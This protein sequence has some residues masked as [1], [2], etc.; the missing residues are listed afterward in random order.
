MATGRSDYPNQVNNVLGFPFIFRGALDVA[1]QR[2]QRGDEAGGR[3]TRWPTLAKEDVPDS[4]LRAYGGKPFQFGR[5]YIIPKPFDSRVLLWEAPA[6]AEAAMETGVARKPYT[7]KE[8][9]VRELESRAVAHPRGACAWSSTR[10]QGRAQAHRLPRGRAPE[11]PARRQDPGRGG[12]RTA[13][14]ARRRK[15]AIDALPEGV[16]GPART[17]SRSSTRPPTRSFEAYAE[18][19]HELRQRKGV[20]PRGRG[21]GAAAI[22]I[23][24]GIMMV[25]EGDADG[26]IAGLTSTTPRPSGRRCRSSTRRAGRLSAWPA[27]TC[28]SFEDGMIFIA[29]TTVNIDPTAEELAEIAVLAADVADTTSTSSRAWRCSRSPTS[30]PTPTSARGKVRE[31][32]RSS[33]ERWPELVDRRRDAGRHRGRA[34][35]RAGD[36]PVLARSR[37]TPTSSSSPTSS[38]PTSPTSCSGGSARSRSS[39]RS[40]PV[41]KRP[42]HVLQR[43]VEVN[44]IV[45]MAAMCVLKAQNME[46]LRKRPAKT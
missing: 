10:R 45:N 20:D 41:S 26:L 37:A 2:D 28:W 31:R 46:E 8:D 25:H 39:G 18:T 44:D 15:E 32:W 23:Y 17:R 24:F 43:G 35:H 42:V 27:C 16:R 33:S 1:R 29:D 3:R 36:L 22:P 14:P 7:S 19:F 30:A 34:E 4:V 5:E 6:V 11:D 21:Q 9:Y 13:D 40:W 12:D 38:R